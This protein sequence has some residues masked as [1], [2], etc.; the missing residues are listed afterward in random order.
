MA[1]GRRDILPCKEQAAGL[2]DDRA[3]PLRGWGMGGWP[4]SSSA[5]RH[6]P[7][8]TQLFL[9]GFLSATLLLP[10]GVAYADA[11]ADL[12]SDGDYAAM[13]LSAG[14]DVIG[15]TGSSDE[16]LGAYAE[17]QAQ[18]AGEDG[19][20]PCDDAQ[21]GETVPMAT[22][23]YVVRAREVLPDGTDVLP[24]AH[25]GLW[26]VNYEGDDV[27]LGL[28][29]NQEEVEGS[30]LESDVNGY[31]WWDVP[32]IAGAEY[33]LLEEWPPPAGHL[34]D[35]Y[36]SEY[37]KLVRKEGE[38]GD[39][40]RLVFESDPDYPRRPTVSRVRNETGGSETGG[41]D[42]LVG[43][44]AVG[45]EP[46]GGEAVG[47]GPAIGGPAGGDS[48]GDNAAGGDSSGGGPVVA[49][50]TT[51]GAAGDNLPNGG[52]V[53]PASSSAAP[54]ARS[55][56]TKQASTQKLPNTSDA[57]YA[58]LAVPCSLGALA[59]VAA[60]LNRRKAASNRH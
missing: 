59:L 15:A 31:L 13:S 48:S 39:A 5:R 26:T 24:G 22:F 25:Y 16:E 2:G 47:G 27:Y 18:P 50:P 10:A 3:R 43:G 6:D 54:Q 30:I 23:H 44:G 14:A 56:S 46:A 57:T 12:P 19:L 38:S 7:R 45:D 40:Y 36:P 29:R 34:V 52:K 41:S 60:S 33:Y 42:E 4:K 1:N 28:G 17:P 55:V 49:R 11:N 37:F 8:K 21:D 9:A 35:P 58:S 51:G 32:V 53:T 20:L